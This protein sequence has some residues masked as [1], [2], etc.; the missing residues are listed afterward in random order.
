MILLLATPLCRR[1][2]RILLVVPLLLIAGCVG[3]A[4][5]TTSAIINP[6]VKSDDTVSVYY[7]L[8]VDGSI[9]D[10]NVGKQLFTFTVGSGQVIPG[11]DNGVLGMKAGEEKTFTVSP[12]QGYG[13][14][15]THP[16]AGK[17]LIFT[18]KVVE[19]NK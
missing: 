3:Q 17:T 19:I 5:P 16:L 4:S 11:F 1:N 10:S 2:I 9:V 13:T 12:E 15:G 18:V 7:T 6:A 8:V 14:T